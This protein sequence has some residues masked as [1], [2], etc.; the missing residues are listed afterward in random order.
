MRRHMPG[1]WLRNEKPQA[2]PAARNFPFLIFWAIS[3]AFGTTMAIIW[4]PDDPQ[5]AGALFESAC[6][7]TAGLLLVPALRVR[8][9]GNQFL[10][11]RA[12]PDGRFGLLAIIGPADRRISA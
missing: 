5:P 10:R 9:C 6:W 2:L 7:L 3:A 8:S 11:V 1:A 4:I 12:Y